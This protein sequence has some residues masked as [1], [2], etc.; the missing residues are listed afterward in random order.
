MN[1]IRRIGP[2]ALVLALATTVVSGSAYGAELTCN[3]IGNVEEFRY[4]WRIRGGV[5]FL[6]GLMFPTNGV[7]NLRNTYGDKVHSELLITAPNGKQGGFYEYASDI[8]ESGKTLMTSHG[9]AWGKK[10]RTERT[11]FDYVKGLARMSKVTPDDGLENRVKKLPAGDDEFRD[12]L[13]AIH[14]LRQNADTLNAPVQTTVYSDGKEYPVMFKPGARKMFMIEGKQTAAR[15]FEIVDAP[16]G[17]KWP[18]GV[19]VW[20]TSDDRRVPVRIEIQQ[21]IAA[22]QLDLQKIESCATLVARMDADGMA[23][24]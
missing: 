18:G 19:T 21:S 15:G 11:I 6:A 14:Y 12:I 16:G 17:K 23:A 13:T 2:A 22:L 3:N 5:R 4:S 9:Y 1:I 20:L 8:D 24:R 7:G 10:A